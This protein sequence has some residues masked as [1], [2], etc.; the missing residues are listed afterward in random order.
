[1]CFPVSLGQLVS[2]AAPTRLTSRSR[3]HFSLPWW[4]LPHSTVPSSPCPKSVH[5]VHVLFHPNPS[6]SCSSESFQWPQGCHDL[7]TLTSLLSVPAA[8]PSG[9]AFLRALLRLFPLPDALRYKHTGLPPLPLCLSVTLAV[10]VS[11]GFPIT[12]ITP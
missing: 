8:H 12:M 7:A 11:F 9:S 3:V 6:M 4:R 5:Q 1:M 10:P 2:H